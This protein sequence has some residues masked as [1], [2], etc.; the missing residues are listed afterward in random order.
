M[1]A[2]RVSPPVASAGAPDHGGRGLEEQAARA[3][4]RTY[5]DESVR[6]TAAHTKASAS[7][8]LPAR[9]RW[10]GLQDLQEPRARRKAQPHQIIGAA[11]GCGHGG[12]A[13]PRQY[14]DFLVVGM[15]QLQRRA[16]A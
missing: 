8:I 3:R 4:G 1:S 6:A 14:L 11:V 10:P 2:G 7:R 9:R 5:A 13:S 16:G 15:P 12:Q